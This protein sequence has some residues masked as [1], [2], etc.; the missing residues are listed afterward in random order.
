MQLE[1]WALVSSYCSSTYRVADPF[2]SLGAFSSFST[3]GP[4]FNLIDDCEHPLLYL[5]ST[6]IASYETAIPWSLQQ[7]LV[8]ICKN[9]LFLL[10]IHGKMFKFRVS[11]SEWLHV[12]FSPVCRVFHKRSH[13]RNRKRF[14]LFLLFVCLFVVFLTSFVSL[15]PALFSGL[16]N[17]SV[18]KMFPVQAGDLTWNSPNPQKYQTLWHMRL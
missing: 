2:S 7:N 12:C 3:G 1:T 13:D 4:V 14:V 10:H 18:G 16:A 5:P 9:V 8:D 17:D 6:G 15:L 11:H